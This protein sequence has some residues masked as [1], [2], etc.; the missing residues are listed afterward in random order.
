MATIQAQAEDTIKA[1]A[2]KKGPNWE[3]EARSRP[4]SPGPD[5]QVGLPGHG[6]LQLTP[7]D[8]SACEA[9]PL[10][11][12][13][14]LPAMSAYSRHHATLLGLMHTPRSPCRCLPE[15]DSMWCCS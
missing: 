15:S 9:R 7:S 10:A 11:P 14:G 5:S 3:A 13:V 6:C 8:D 12:Q 1:G 2:A 4:W